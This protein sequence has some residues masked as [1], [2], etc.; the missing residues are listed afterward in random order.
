MI[1]LVLGALCTAAG[2]LVGLN[3]FRDVGYPDSATLLRVGGLVRSGQMY[4]DF[5]RPPYQ[6]SVYAPLTYV[7]H[8]IPYALGE[9]VGLSHQVAVRSGV[10]AAFVLCLTLLF[11]IGRLTSSSPVGGSLAVLFAASIFPLG[12]WTTQIRSEFWAVAFSLGAVLIVMR[13]NRRQSLI[14]AAILAGIAP[15][16]KQTFVTASAAVFIWLML[17]RRFKSAAIWSAT[18]FVTLL[19]GFGIAWW[20]EPMMLEHL[21][22]LADPELEYRNAL[23]IFV[24]ALSQPVI[25][26]AAFGVVLGLS[27]RRKDVLLVSTFC[28]LSWFIAVATIPH[29]GGSINYF[30]EPLLASSILGAYALREIEGGDWLPRAARTLIALVF[31]WGCA[32]IVANDLRYLRDSSQAFASYEERRERWISFT[33]A[34]AGHRI[35]ST[36]PAF[37]ALSS[38][39]EVPDPFLNATL[40]RSGKWSYAPVV[41]QLE[42]GEFDLVV[43]SRGYPAQELEYRGLALWS[44]AMRDALTAR[45]TRGCVFEDFD[46]WLPSPSSS[47]LL[48]R[49]SEVGCSRENDRPRAAIEPARPLRVPGP[50]SEHWALGIRHWQA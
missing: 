50:S 16:V 46:I 27:R 25:P 38:T 41:A 35:L 1:V 19:A 22:F 43:V 24:S 14:V 3:N 4:P 26:F 13:S 47:T 21:S 10:L 2:S 30:W 32:S 11:V 45:Y 36:Y 9:Q 5:Q 17:S 42:A 7:L 6:L 23:R 18:V 29:V 12:D 20:R 28:T 37:T 48:N 34:I 33:A 31:L 8:A 49:L 44:V 40:E 15:V 39:P